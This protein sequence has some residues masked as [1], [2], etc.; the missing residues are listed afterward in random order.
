MGEL[1]QARMEELIKAEEAYRSETMSSS[2]FEV[3]AIVKMAKRFLEV[4]TTTSRL[5]LGPPE[6]NETIKDAIES[7]YG[8]IL[9]REL[10]VLELTEVNEKN[11]VTLFVQ[12]CS[13]AMEQEVGLS[14]ARRRYL[15]ALRKAALP[16]FV[17]IVYSPIQLGYFLRLTVNERT[18]I[19]LKLIAKWY[20]NKSKEELIIIVHFWPTVDGSRHHDVWRHCRWIFKEQIVFEEMADL[21]DQVELDDLMADP[22]MRSVGDYLSEEVAIRYLPQRSVARALS[23]RDRMEIG[24][25]LRSEEWNRKTSAVEIMFIAKHFENHTDMDTDFVMNTRLKRAYAVLCS[26]ATYVSKKVCVIRIVKRSASVRRPQTGLESLEICT[27]VLEDLM[28]NQNARMY[29]QYPKEN[30]TGNYGKFSTKYEVSPGPLSCFE[31]NQYDA[32]LLIKTAIPINLFFDC[33]VIVGISPSVFKMDRIMAEFDEYK[34]ALNPN[35]RLIFIGV[36]SLGMY[37]P[38]DSRQDVL[39]VSGVTEY[40]MY[41]VNSFIEL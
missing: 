27:A 2:V 30:G 25:C 19:C 34:K 33:F 37:P 21:I 39:M 35:S 38:V 7:G 17:Y 12:L 28:R 3:D 16:L 26:S 1:N 9:L 36:D 41:R 29:N 20:R 8:S 5:Q 14:S 4:G 13:L 31:K 22:H 10:S 40:T 23:Q 24:R 15:S 18:F 6:I 11:R 32:A